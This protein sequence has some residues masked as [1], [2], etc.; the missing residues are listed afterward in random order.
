MSWWSEIRLKWRAN[1]IK[2]KLGNMLWDFTKHSG[3]HHLLD[4]SW[5]ADGIYQ[6]D[7]K[8]INRECNDYII[9]YECRAFVRNRKAV[10]LIDLKKIKTEIQ[11]LYDEMVK[12][13][14]AE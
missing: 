13:I 1:R 4:L 6:N 10:L 11:R 5:D 3:N 12:R 7:K 8:I 2:S 14:E 9:D